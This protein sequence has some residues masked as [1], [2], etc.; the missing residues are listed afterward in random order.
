MSKTDHDRGASF[1]PIDPGP[2]W[3]VPRVS[4]PGLFGM[5]PQFG[6]EWW[7][8]VGTVYDTDGQPFSI[9]L[10][11]LR[12]GLGALQIG[13]GIT[14][15]GWRDAQG[16]H[17]LSGQGFGL[18]TA[19]SAATLPSV[20]IPPVDDYTYSARMVPLLELVDRSSGLRKDLHLNLPVPDGWDGWNFEYLAKQSAGHPVGMAGSVYALGAHGRGYLTSAESAQTPTAEYRVSFTVEDRRGTVMEGISG[21]V[22]PQMFAA[23]SADAPASYE[24]A[25]PHLRIR[26]GGRLVIDGATHEIERG[27][28]WLDRQMID[29]GQPPDGLSASENDAKGL[30]SY[31]VRQAPTTKELYRGDWMGFV[32][33]DGTVMV[34][35][36]FWQQST[37]QWITGSKTGKPPRH[38]F[39]NLYFRRDGGDR[40]PMNGGTGLA[41]KTVRHPDDWDFDVNILDP[42]KPER[43]PHWMSPLS[44]KTYATAWQIDLSPKL[45]RFGLPSTLYARV[46]S[47]N[48]EIISLAKNGAFFEGAAI[49]YA[50]REMTQQVGHAFVEQMGFD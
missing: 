35:A 6:R 18:G 36:E 17:Y 1:P 23:G 25:Q 41:A 43:S 15:I 10:E 5:Q 19:D 29:Q 37:P 21:Y 3:N 39:G 2:S 49:V 24:C 30:R 16:S 9:Q 40:P 38:G 46:I 34:L 27:Y 28:L 44:G 14:G 48:C 32:F 33:D 4:S 8:Y 42:E 11:I 45:A 31:L 20:V 7:Y 13:Y 12:A 26:P 47:D 50:D 22:G